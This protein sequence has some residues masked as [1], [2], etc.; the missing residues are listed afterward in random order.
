MGV[1]RPVLGFE[2]CELRGDVGDL[3]HCGKAI[4]SSINPEPKNGRSRRPR[5]RAQAAETHRER[6]DGKVFVE[7]LEDTITL[8]RRRWPEESE[9][10]MPIGWWCRP[11]REAHRLF[12]QKRSEAVRNVLRQGDSEEKPIAQ[13]VPHSMPCRDSRI[14]WSAAVVANVLTRSRSPGIRKVRT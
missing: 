13:P 4:R 11:P 8:E 6:F 10:Q 3:G 9:R 1:E 14:S 5:E 7:E 2:S 12:L